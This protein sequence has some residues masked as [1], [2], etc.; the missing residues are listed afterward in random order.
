MKKTGKPQAPVGHAKVNRPV[1]DE[2]LKERDWLQQDFAVALA[3]ELRRKNY[4]LGAL[5]RKLSGH[6]RF[7]LQ[8]ATATARVFGKPLQEV[9]AIL[10]V[11]EKIDE[12]GTIDDVGVVHLRKEA[13]A[14]RQGFI[15]CT[16][17]AWEGA[18]LIA[19]TAPSLRR[20]LY[21]VRTK[22]EVRLL[23]CLGVSGHLASVSTAFG[24]PKL[25]HIT[26]GDIVWKARVVS[27]HFR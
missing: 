21:V 2:W 11:D 27:I 10:G 1:F 7:T 19:E 18:R 26:I 23:Q 5:S 15:F 25:S 22:D 24:E 14:H 16:A 9:M 8:E 6:R 12:A 17:D 20:G 4:S 13:A 3:K